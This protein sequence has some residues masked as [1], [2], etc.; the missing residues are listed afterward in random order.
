MKRRTGNVIRERV[1]KRLRLEMNV[2]S[3]QTE[4]EIEGF[5]KYIQKTYPKSLKKNKATG[6]IEFMYKKL[7]DEEL[8]SLLVYLSK[9]E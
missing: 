6:E 5:L 4:K 3:L 1:M 9:K 7:G 8:D 2:A